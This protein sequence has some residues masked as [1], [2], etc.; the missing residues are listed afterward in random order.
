MSDKPKQR[1][2]TFH[3]A[4]YIRAYLTAHKWNGA[5]RAM[6]NKFGVSVWAVRA[7]NSGKTHTA[8]DCDKCHP[9]AEKA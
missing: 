4:E 7:A 6:A 5:V 1:R 3:E 8:C 2:L 9:K